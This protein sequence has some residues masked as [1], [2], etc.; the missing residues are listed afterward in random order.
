MADMLPM[1]PL[2]LVAFPGEDVNLHVFESRYR[3][4]THE[5]DATGITFA[6][7]PYFK[8]EEF[9]FATEVKLTEIAKTYPD[10]KMD[11]RTKAI[12]RVKVLD[13]FSTHP[14]KLYPGAEVEPALWDTEADIDLSVM[15]V[16]LIRKLYDTMGID[17]VPVA[18]PANFL[19][20]QNIHK[21]GLSQQDELQLLE[22]SQEVDRQRYI[23]THLHKFVPM[24]QEAEQLR[25]K[26]ALNG[27]FKHLKPGL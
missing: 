5:C 20:Y 25:K 23:L 12:G 6:I 27:H 8:H 22:L 26:A 24:M 21:I 3:Q 18:E 13:F 11:I 17:N 15:I 10:G 16:G 19:T 9:S 1:F 4:L 2:G 14:G 7:L